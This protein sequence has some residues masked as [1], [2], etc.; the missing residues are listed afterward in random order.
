MIP[1]LWAQ[2]GLAIL[3]GEFVMANL[4]NRDF[5]MDVAN[6]GD[7]VN[8]R[9]PS[10]FLMKRKVETDDITVQDAISTL[11]QVPLDQHIHVAFKISDGEK[12]KSFQEL[13]DIYLRPAAQGIARSIDRILAGQAPQ[14]LAHSVGSL[15]EMTKTNAQ[16]YLVAAGQVMSENKAY[17]G[18]RNLVITPSAQAEM[19]K[20]ELFVS[21]E[22]RG[23]D[24][25][26]LRDASLGQLMGFSIYMDQNVPGVLLATT[27]YAS[28][29]T[30]AVEPINETTLSVNVPAYCAIDGEYVW[31]AGEGRVHVVSSATDDGTNTSAIVLTSGLVNAVAANAVVTVYKACEANATT[32]AG[33]AKGIVVQKH[34]G[35]GA[36]TANRPVAGQIIA[37]GTGVNRHVY[38][39]V[40][41]YVDPTSVTRTTLWLDRPLDATVTALDD[42]FVGP[43]GSLNF[44]FCKDALALVS[45]P[46]AVPS[47]ELGVRSAVAAYNNIAMRITMQYNITSQ[48]TIVNL[49]LLCGVAVLDENLGVVL[50]S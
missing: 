20:T 4:V 50:L 45:R 25:T 40:E 6:F 24:G 37:F 14:F 49:D 30:L 5:S 36:W 26:A 41:A 17:Q 47:N 11:V 43:A 31:I 13:V 1:E 8:T 15:Q 42:V 3:E 19:L 33:Y 7:V 39:V 44:G 10:A 46:L 23:D 48:A 18:G 38:T 32:A 9:R 12:S 27:D 29:E 16:D 21:A 22:K 28:G 2:T 35:G 34:G